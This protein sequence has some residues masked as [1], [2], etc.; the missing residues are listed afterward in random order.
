[1]LVLA[2]LQGFIRADV[3]VALHVGILL[4][5]LTRSDWGFALSR[6]MQAIVS[7]AGVAIA[8]GIQFYLMH[9]AYPHASYGTTPV[10]QFWANLTQPLRWVPFVLFMLPW[11]WLAVSLVRRRVTAEKPGI[12]LVA[13]SAIYLCVWSVVGKIDEVRIFLPYA[14]ALI[15]AACACAIQRFPADDPGQE[16]ESRRAVQTMS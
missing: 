2:G 11:W 6:G 9:I 8:G 10:V 3:A 1:M 14:V 13:A 5:C 7:V 15:P 12:A 16:L 4:I